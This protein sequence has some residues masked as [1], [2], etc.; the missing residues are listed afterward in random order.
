MR[1]SLKKKK[2]HFLSA[3]NGLFVVLFLARCDAF[4][5]SRDAA[6]QHIFS[7]RVILSFLLFKSLQIKNFTSKEER[8]ALLTQFS[9]FCIS[10]TTALGTE[11][12][13]LYLS[14]QNQS[15]LHMFFEA[16]Q[17]KK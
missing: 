5:K 11:I 12:V 13:F 6:L 8:A 16:P 4:A 7:N 2:K 17:I 1:F 3:K 10:H 15:T 9:S 14:S